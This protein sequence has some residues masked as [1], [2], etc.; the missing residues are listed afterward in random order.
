[1]M[2]KKQDEYV[3]ETKNILKKIMLVK[4]E[5][6]N[7]DDFYEVLYSDYYDKIELVKD[8]KYFYNQVKKYVLDIDIKDIINFDEMK[9]KEYKDYIIVAE[10]LKKSI[11]Q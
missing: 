3:E 10:G 2:K 5:I 7:S 1:M 6:Y 11:D 8:V 9:L 4:P